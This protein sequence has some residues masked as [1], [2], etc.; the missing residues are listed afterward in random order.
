[1]QT[2]FGGIQQI[3]WSRLLLG[4]LLTLICGLSV[5]VLMLQV[6]HVPFPSGYPSHAPVEQIDQAF[7][8]LGLLLLL[9]KWAYSLRGAGIVVRWLV[10]FVLYAM[11]R[12]T[13]RGTIMVGV[14]TTEYAYPL[15]T[16]LPRLLGFLVLTLFCVLTEPKLL[17]LWQKVLGAG[18]IY[19]VV[20][21]AC[22]PLIA[23]A[24]EAL[25]ARFAH[26]QHD[27]VY[28][29]P[30]GAHVLIPAY[31][32]Y[33]EPVIASVLCAA[34]VWNQLSKRSVLR[35]LEFIVLI[36]LIKRSMF[37]PFI[38]AWYERQHW[39]TAL[40][41]AGQFSLETITLAL[42]AALTWQ[43]ASKPESPEIRVPL[44]RP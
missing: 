34:L 41:S 7:I 8:V 20:T 29:M 38:Y 18:L 22:Q 35:Y 15:L 33:L 21:F 3:R 32:T 10:L 9:S 2:A 25:L 26:L 31:I 28:A 23:K 13:L 14:T 19:V 5:H 36:L 17:R 1:M 30:Y 40:A 6:L 24:F 11:L 37:P 12:E 44:R 42:F 39:A 4:L 43:Y 16:L 27:E